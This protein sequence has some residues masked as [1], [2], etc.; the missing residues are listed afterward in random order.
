LRPFEFIKG[1]IPG[2]IE[3]KSITVIDPLTAEIFGGAPTVAGPVINPATAIRV[4][5]VLSAV[6]L[7]STALGSLPAKVFADDGSGKQSA[8]DHP[9][10]SI[11]HDWSN[12]W[13]AAGELRTRLTVDALLH[14][15]GFAYANRVGDRVGE[16]IRLD[17]TTVTPK[18]DE[19]TGEPFYVQRLPNARERR[20]HYREILHVASPLDLSPIRAGKE[21]IGLALIMET[22]AARLFADGARP[23]LVFAN[24][25]GTPEGEK[26]ATVI[27]RLRAAYNAWKSSG[28]PM[29]LDG[30]WKAAQFAFSSTDAQFLENR[31]FQI[32]E[33][34]RLFRVPPPMLFDFE[35]T[36]LNNYEETGRQFTTYTLRPWL[37]AWERA[38]SRVLLSPDERAAGYYVEFVTDAL[39][40]ADTAKR[41]EAYSKMRTAGIFTANEI[42]AR[43]NLPPHPDGDTLANPNTT[44]GAPVGANDNAEPKDEAA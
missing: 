35:R 5:A 1:L 25:N 13:M 11:I 7:I 33:I 4:P 27:K 29:F 23:S 18:H 6:T 10:Y 28:G 30:G 31:R 2:R 26:G 19:V 42:R 24:D 38:Y 12:D 32:G 37:D 3:K 20:F 44:P 39:L 41:A 14:D 17:P 8:K 9:A 36:T 22:H 43:E 34:C 21:A 15:H 40:S 16:L